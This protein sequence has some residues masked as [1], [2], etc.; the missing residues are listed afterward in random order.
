M[1]PASDSKEMISRLAECGAD[2]FR[3]NFSHGTHERHKLVTKLIR[4]VEE[5]VDRPI[6]IIGDLQGPKLRV[7]ELPEGGVPL[8]DGE[9]YVLA[10]DG[11]KNDETQCDLPHPEIFDIAEPDTDLLLDDG[12]IRLG[13]VEVGD[14]KIGTVVKVG[15]LLKPHKGV[16]YPAKAIPISAMSEKDRQDLEFALEIG[17]DW[18]A[19]SFVQ[20][21][22]DL[23]QA[24]EIID[25]RAKLIAKIEK[26]EAVR[27][28]DD[29][30]KECDAVM[31][32]R[33]D[34]GVEI[35]QEEVP[36]LQ[37]RMIKQCRAESRPVIVAT[38][39]LESMT[40]SA[41]PTR[42]EASDI[43]TALYD[44]TDAVMLSAESAS[45]KYPAEAVEFMR[46]IIISTEKDPEYRISLEREALRLE[47][48]SSAAIVAA[49]CTVA[50]VVKASAIVSFSKTG[51]TTLRASRQ[52]PV[53]PLL[54]LTPLESTARMATLFWGVR[55][56]KTPDLT[57]DDDMVVKATMLASKY[58]FVKDGDRL[59]VTAG[60]PL[61]KPGRTNILR[62]AVAGEEQ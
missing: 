37:K 54:G 1:G 3:L 47:M 38:Q 45:G 16:N 35:S 21:P 22:E 18:I 49:A 42:A 41:T 53:C 40:H 27:N 29:L 11:G 9:K 13:I 50:E 31:I 43:A 25:N 23:I 12:N 57:S 56:I 24:K 7:G 62:L 58:G 17:I 34:L 10:L 20:R 59:I 2:L 32:A 60:L 36:A 44:G 8:I 51:N 48:A 4:K 5:E 14:G 28:F 46:R 52:R 6:G 30:I 19:M 33:G 26:P 39:M 55:S 61:G 15:G